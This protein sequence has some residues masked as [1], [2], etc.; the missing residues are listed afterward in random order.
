MTKLSENDVIHVATL[1]KLELTP[2][3]IKKFQKQLSKV[4]DYIAELQ[5]VDIE[6]VEPTSQTTGLSGVYRT[7]EINPQYLLSQEDAISGKDDTVNGLFKVEAILKER[8][9]K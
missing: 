6:K 4:V 3:E 5:E 8:K 7:D 1:A 2:E 9:S